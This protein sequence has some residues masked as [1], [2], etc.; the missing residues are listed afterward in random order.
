MKLESFMVE[1][2]LSQN[3]VADGNIFTIFYLVVCKLFFTFTPKMGEI[4]QSDCYFK[5]VGSTTK[6]LVGQVHLFHC[7]VFDGSGCLLHQGWGGWLKET[8][9]GTWNETSY[10]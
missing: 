8:S 10:T 2:W 3:G 6:F 5:W 4:I 9:N 7:L 1:V